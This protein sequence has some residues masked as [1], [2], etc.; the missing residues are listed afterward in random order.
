MRTPL[1]L[2]QQYFGYSSFRSYQ[3]TAVENTIAGNDTFVLMPTG[4]G[5]SLCYQI[6]ALALEGTAIIISPLI[7]LMKD[8]VDAL[9]VN[10]IA[11]AYLNSSQATEEQNHILMQLR[12]GDIKLLYVSPEKISAESGHFIRFLKQIRISLFAIDEAHCVSHWGHDF[13]PDY[14]SLSMLRESF[15]QTPFIALTA[16]AD[17]ITR[18]D[19]IHQLKLN[20]PKVLV[21]SFNRPNI[22]YYVQPKKNVFA[23][24]LQ[25]IN[26]HP[27]DSGIIY[28]LSRK[29]TESLAR[30][31]QEYQV[32]TRYYHAG[33]PSQER[34]KVQEEFLKDRVRVIVATIAF[35][36]G[37]DKSNVRFVIHADLPK[38]IE[39]YYQETGRAGRDGL[40]STAILFY[41]SADVIKLR[42]FA[43]ND[44]NTE[45]S[46]LMLKKLKQMADFAETQSCRRQYLMHYFG[47]RHEGNCSSCD[48][49]LSSF[50]KSDVTI[51][52]QK[53][54]SAVK[55]LKERYGKGLIIDFLRGSQSAKI[56]DWMR[57][58][59]TYSVGKDYT[60]AF[61]T[62]LIQHLL[63][64]GF[65][66]EVT[67]P[68]PVLQLTEESKAILFQGK[69]VS[70]QLLQEK[71]VVIT[72]V[73]E[74]LQETPY[75]GID[76]HKELFEILRLLRRQLAEE[77]DVPPYIIF[78]D[79]TLQEMALYLP[80]TEEE[81][82]QINGLG[83]FKMAK[84]R[85]T[86]LKKINQYC[87]Q[88][89]LKS[90]IDQKRTKKSRTVPQYDKGTNTNLSDTFQK[91]LVL[92]RQGNSV[93]EIAMIRGLSAYTIENHLAECVAHGKLDIAELID[94]NK[95]PVIMK[96]A[97]EKGILS[98]RAIKESL[99]DSYSYF[100]IRLTV[101]FM[102][103]RN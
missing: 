16:S 6:P 46:A 61:W 42:N 39:S 53:L 103:S 10:G 90:R 40:S 101:A 27:Q 97:E 96:I 54:L 14:L 5:K 13:R 63:S 34:A 17:E 44:D 76:I 87:D 92:F 74:P 11:A 73:K 69:K 72:E 48:Y 38:N 95:L 19:I 30:Q 86:F 64:T 102:K 21:A 20:R 60:K 33:M 24:I 78:S 99:D 26:E 82:Q 31:L 3:Q 85:H 62:T 35:G 55:R 9:K 36:M 70:M 47:E 28:C 79:A 1:E 18:Q 75:P 8:Q 12:T 4:G 67:N 2:L 59:P 68:Y 32:E 23:G 84:Y 7:A 57:Q 88:N 98:L 45:Q 100:D 93:A 29:S 25:Y 91:S 56:T 51:E 58:I 22:H 89:G 50:H 94:V 71:A 15:S 43:I 77:E 41:S 52:A 49:C 83:A 65:L 80:Q 66:R 37:I 81:L